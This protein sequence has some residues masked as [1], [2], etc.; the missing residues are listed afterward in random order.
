MRN[1]ANRIGRPLVGATAAVVATAAIVGCSSGHTPVSSSTTSGS[2]AVAAVD[3]C[4]VGKWV[5]TNVASTFS[6]PGAFVTLTG[7]AGLKL[8]FAS[9]GSETADWS[10]MAPL[11]TT[12]PVDVTQTYHGISHYHVTASEGTLS[13]LSADYSGWSG[14][15]DWAGQISQVTGANPILAEQYSCSST[16]LTEQNG[17]WQASF[18]R[19]R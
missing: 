7:G 4:V 16:T 17:N 3:P 10:S 2:R 1:T 14:Q 18:R 13:F 12:I 9:N 5:S 11:A 19:T 6:V 15:Q 8:T